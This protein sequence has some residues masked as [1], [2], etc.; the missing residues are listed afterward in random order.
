MVKFRLYKNYFG[1]GNAS[2]IWIDN[3]ICHSSALRKLID[4]LTSQDLIISITALDRDSDFFKLVSEKERQ[5][6]VILP[7]DNTIISETVIMSKTSDF[8]PVFDLLVKSEPRCISLYGLKENVEIDR[9]NYD[10]LRYASNTIEKEE[11][12]GYAVSILLEECCVKITFSTDIYDPVNLFK[13]IK[14][15]LQN[16]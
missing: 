14:T 12:V 10:E 6:K 4:I 9:L 5:F 13:T 11:T 16:G 3:F 15:E 1:I 7:T 8:L 2:I